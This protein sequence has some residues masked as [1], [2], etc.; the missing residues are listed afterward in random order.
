MVEHCIPVKA[1]L[2][3][4]CKQRYSV[5]RCITTNL[6]QNSY[7]APPELLSLHYRQLNERVSPLDLLTI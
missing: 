4:A 7:H 2:I 6:Y 3:F 1:T 5:S